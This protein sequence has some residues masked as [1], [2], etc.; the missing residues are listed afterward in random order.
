MTKH[1]SFAAA[2]VLAASS[3]PATSPAPAIGS[4]HDVR[5]GVL[6]LF[7]PKQLVL[8]PMAGGILECMSGGERL[9]VRASLPLQ[10]AG[11]GITTAGQALLAKP[12][13]CDD[14]QGGYAEFVV[15]VPGRISRHYSGRLEI[16]P[17]PGE[18]LI[19]VSMELETAVASVVA[20]ESLPGSSLE[21]L[22][23]QAVAAR[24]FLAAGKGRHRKFNFCDTTHCQFLR[25]PPRTQSSAAQAALA[26]RGMVLAYKD[27]AF[28]AMYSS[29]CGGQTHS[30]E[31]LG[32]SVRDYP[33][34]SVSCAYCRRHPEKWVSR[35]S[36]NDAAGLAPTESARLKLA[37]KLGWKTFSSN[38]YSSRRDG[39]SVLLEG[40]GA[41]HGIG[42]CQRGAADMA[43]NGASFLEILLHYY[44]NTMVKRLP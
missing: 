27:E 35:I 19:I 33:Y 44:P 1:W 14:G 41:G 42:L 15:S 31:E 22:K 23:A 32:I 4:G 40:V 37:R 12:V 16:Q 39:S 17:G 21:A 36:E 43:R 29:S 25:E 26:T 8:S 11:P 3:A 38:S 10:L 2:L 18:L 7:H 20:A 5:I 30:L 13:H 9:P 6:G 28:A 24:S 34:F